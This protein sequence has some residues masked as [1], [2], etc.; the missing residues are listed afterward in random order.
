MPALKCTLP[1]LMLVTFFSG[2]APAQTS[3][4]YKTTYRVQVQYEMWRNGST[5]WETEF[6]TTN[7][8]DAVTMLAL[9]ENAL[10]NGTLSEIMNCGPDWIAVDVRLTTKKEYYWT[11]EPLW[12]QSAS[13]YR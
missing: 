9:L 6:E 3:S 13:W 11:K 5:Y 12:I 8:N 4:L 10:D 7:Y 1:L 2:Q